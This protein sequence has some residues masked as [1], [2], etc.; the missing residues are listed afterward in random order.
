MRA[1]HSPTIQ[2]RRSARSPTRALLGALL[3]LTACSVGPSFTRPE[4]PVPPAWLAHPD[5]RLSAESELNALWWKSF[6]DPALNQVVNLAYKQNLPL[7]IAALRIVEARAQLGISTGKQYPQIVEAFGKADAVGLSES[8]ANIGADRRFL[9][10]QVGFDAAWELDFWGKY[11]R[12]VEAEAAALLASEADYNSGI[13]S[14]TAEVARTYV[15]IRTYD[16]L[17]LET[18][19]NANLQEEGLKIAESRFKNGATSELDV[20]QARALFES[21]RATIPQLQA[22]LQQSLNALSTLLGQPPGNLEP[23]LGGLKGIP[24]PPSTV[25]VS[26]PA[27]MLRRRPDIRSAELAAAAQCAKV[28][29]ATA[30]LY[31]SFSLVG[32]IG[33]EATR[34]T[35][36]KINLFSTNSLFYSVGPELNWPFFTFGRTRNA[37]RVEDARLQQLLINYRDTVLRADQEVEDALAGYLHAQDALLFQQASVTAAQRSVEISLAQYREGATDYERVLDAQRSLL[38][39]QTNLTQLTSSVDTY[40]ISV[41]KALGGGWEIRNGQ[42]LIPEPTVKEMKDRTNW[43]DMLT[44]PSGPEKKQAEQPKPQ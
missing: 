5:P 2:R 27:E 22:S 30:D 44:E 33:F 43:D 7:Q 26:M 4:A 24:A 28:G 25:P 9:D 15:A 19:E 12:G 32:S 31:P 11:R 1:S 35:A 41:F 40:L 16:A 3:A 38:T 36:L 14:L 34:A 21:T 37:I 8:T 6:N 18:Q 13:V 10:F 17:I 23:L 20:T 39:Q 29:V 42:P